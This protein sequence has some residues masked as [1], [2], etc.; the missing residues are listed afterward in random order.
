MGASTSTAS[1]LANLEGAANEDHDS[2]TEIIALLSSTGNGEL[3]DLSQ[4]AEH[5]YDG[6]GLRFM[7]LNAPGLSQCGG[8]PTVVEVVKESPTLFPNSALKLLAETKG[9]NLVLHANID[10]VRKYLPSVGAA[11]VPAVALAMTLAGS[12]G[13][14]SRP[15]NLLSFETK[16]GV[17]TVGITPEAESLLEH[18]GV[19]GRE[20]KAISAVK[21]GML[22]NTDTL[23][24]ATLILSRVG[25]LSFT[26]VHVLGTFATIPPKS[27]SDNGV[28]DQMVTR[29][30]SILELKMAQGSHR[31]QFYILMKSLEGVGIAF[32]MLASTQMGVRGSKDAIAMGS[33]EAI[34]IWKG[35]SSEAWWVLPFD[36]TDAVRMSGGAAGTTMLVRVSREAIH[37]T[38]KGIGLVLPAFMPAASTLLSCTRFMLPRSHFMHPAVISLLRLSESMA[39]VAGTNPLQ[40]INSMIRAEAFTAARTVSAVSAE[41]FGPKCITVK[42]Y[43]KKL[44]HCCQ[45]LAAF[46][47]GTGA[48]RNFFRAETLGAHF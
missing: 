11:A 35:I 44:C 28:K 39:A 12:R 18:L 1:I 21:L 25:A 31:S 22:V 10:V 4:A 29:L 2:M 23:K 33:E 42:P 7:V 19:T 46:L 32:G 36:P 9:G 3:L 24:K 41:G 38:F 8:R 15:V 27:D 6:S 5:S 30:A 14:L 16:E 20:L 40:T 13:H 45:T 17:T 26:R 48:V 43:N 34:K 37:L 47:M